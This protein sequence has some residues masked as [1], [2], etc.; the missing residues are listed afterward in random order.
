M[1]PGT[2][3][4]IRHIADAVKRFIERAVAARRDDG[5]KTFADGFGSE[6]ARAARSGGLFQSAFRADGVQ[7]AAKISRLIAL[8]RRVENDTSTHIT[9]FPELRGASRGQR[10]GA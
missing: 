3:E 5:V 6:R 10:N 8:C 4:T 1:K 2:L 7:V 9:I